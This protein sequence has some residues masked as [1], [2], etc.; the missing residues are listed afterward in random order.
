[1]QARSLEGAPLLAIGDGAMSF[2]AEL[3]EAYPPAT[4]QQRRW[5]HKIGGWLRSKL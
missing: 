5:V 1:M 2:L 4:C 3:D